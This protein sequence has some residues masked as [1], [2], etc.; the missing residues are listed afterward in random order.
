MVQET[1]NSTLKQYQD[2]IFKSDPENG[3]LMEKRPF[4]PLEVTIKIHSSTFFFFFFFCEDYVLAAYSWC[5][6]E[7]ETLPAL[8]L[9]NFR[10][11]C[12]RL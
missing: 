4:G 9:I 2:A 6:A 7:D 8:V 3:N 10:A 5:E 11:K 12:L 1:K